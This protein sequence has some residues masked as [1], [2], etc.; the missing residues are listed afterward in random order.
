M[1]K[2]LLEVCFS[3]LAVFWN[4]MVSNRLS[5]GK[6]ILPSFA[7]LAYVHDRPYEQIANL[8]DRTFLFRDVA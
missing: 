7:T 8:S 4:C 5:D 2:M 6:N 3:F 1:H